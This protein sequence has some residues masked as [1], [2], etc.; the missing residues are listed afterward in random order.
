V[1]LELRHAA[2]CL[3]RRGGA[4]LAAGEAL[5][6]LVDAVDT[7]PDFA[8]RTRPI[9]RSMRGDIEEIRARMHFFYAEHFKNTDRNQQKEHLRQAADSYPREIDVLIAMHHFPDADLAWKQLTEQ[10]LNDTIGYYREQIQQFSQFQNVNPAQEGD[11]RRMLAGFY[12]Q[13]AWLIANTDGDLDEALRYS[14]LSLD[15]APETSSYLD[16]LGRCYFAKKDYASAVKYQSR[17]AALEPHSGQIHR[18]LEL[19]K[20]TLAEQK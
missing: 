5:K 11:I 14:K 1:A 2:R 20:K 18:Q 16:T 12:N 10:R 7:D 19:F 8:K 3:L 9:M 13:L 6:P 4:D 17:A 15:L